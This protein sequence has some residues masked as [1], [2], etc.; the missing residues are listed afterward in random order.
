MG[1]CRGVWGIGKILPID[2]E[3][4]GVGGCAFASWYVLLLLGIL[5]NWHIYTDMEWFDR[6]NAN[7]MTRSREGTTI[8]DGDAGRKSPTPRLGHRLQLPTNDS[9][10]PSIQHHASCVEH[11]RGDSVLVLCVCFDELGS[12]TMDVA[13][14][15]SLGL[16]PTFQTP[17]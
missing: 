14:V 9:E 12:Q 2:A 4:G 7:W 5:D 16:H 3:C 1:E 6:L 10:Q 11:H 15:C 13:S 8:H 17:S